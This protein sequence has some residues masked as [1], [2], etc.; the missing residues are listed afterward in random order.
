MDTFPKVLIISEFSFNKD[1]IDYYKY[2]W[3]E[4]KPSYLM[5]GIPIF[6]FGL[7]DIYFISEAK[8]KFELGIIKR[9]FKQL[10][11]KIKN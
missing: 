3:P 6:I 7:N 11:K 8:K 1:L 9:G 5:S 2:S 4:K 10:L